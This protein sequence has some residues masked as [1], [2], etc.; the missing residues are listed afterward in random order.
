MD[1]WG[2]EPQTSR[3]R[4]GRSTTELH[5]RRVANDKDVEG[6]FQY[7]RYKNLHFKSYRARVLS[8]LTLSLIGKSCSPI[9]AGLSAA[10]EHSLCRLQAISSNSRD[11]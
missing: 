1:G 9:A 7:I 8:Q 11:K 5:A 10:F 6:Q 3:M 2:I 4:S